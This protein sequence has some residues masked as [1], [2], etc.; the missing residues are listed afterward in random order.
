LRD[1]RVAVNATVINEKEKTGI[2]LFALNLLR[3]LQTLDQTNHYDVFTLTGSDTGLISGVN[4]KMRPLP[5]FFKRFPYLH[6]WMIW[7]AWYYTGHSCQLAAMKP[8]VL[9]SLDFDVPLHTKCPSVCMIY[10]LTPL[11]FKDM[12]SKHFRIRYKWQLNHAARNAAK[13]IAISQDCKKDIVNYL[14]MDPQK[15]IVAYPGFDSRLFKPESD[16]QKVKEFKERYALGDEYILFMGALNARKNVIRIIEAFETLKKEYG[17]KHKLVIAGKRAW[18]DEII[19]EKIRSSSYNSDIIVPGYLPYEAVPILMSGADMFIFPSLHEGFGIPLLEAMA[20]GTPVITSNTSSLP[21]VV[22]DAGLLV[23]P[24]NVG[25][26]ASAMHRVISEPVLRETMVRKGLE[27]ARLFAWERTARS[28][29]TVL[30]Q[31]VQG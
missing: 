1:I 31:T 27:Q 10:D 25:D 19:F 16:L 8:D 28:V 9:L 24:Y 26:I 20:C 2:A 14:G 15:I 13:I 21:E 7:Y 5:G 29:L 6:Q 12:F 11:I 30:E 3:S 23:D 17:T 22:G 4:F 18:N